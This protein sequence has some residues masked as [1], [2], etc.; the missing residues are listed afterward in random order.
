MIILLAVNKIVLLWHCFRHIAKKNLLPAKKGKYQTIC[1][2]V[3]IFYY[4]IL[5]KVTETMKKELTYSIK[6]G[7]IQV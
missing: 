6:N 7:S 1:I 3:Y 4:G 2:K 5:T